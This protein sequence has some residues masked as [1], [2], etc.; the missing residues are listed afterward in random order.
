MASILNK[1]RNPNLFDGHTDKVFSIVN[2]PTN[3]QVNSRTFLQ[4]CTL[5][6]VGTT[7]VVQLQQVTTALLISQE[8]ISG[9]W[10]STIHVWDARQPHSVRRFHG[11]FVA[12]EGLDMDRS[13][14]TRIDSSGPI[15]LVHFEP[16]VRNMVCNGQEES[17]CLS[18]H[19]DGG[20]QPTLQVI[21]RLG[22]L[23]STQVLL[24]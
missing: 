6:R 19:R 1:S 4:I 13:H 22:L 23:V 9:G 15:R 16:I 17:K 10:D 14:G 12:G 24:V 20:Y 11:P 18:G 8:F 2:H 5:S 3:P 7:V 21:E